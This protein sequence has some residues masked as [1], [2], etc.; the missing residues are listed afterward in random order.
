MIIT[1]IIL[2]AT[3]LKYTS[4]SVEAIRPNEYYDTSDDLWT[5]MTITYVLF[6]VALLKGD[7]EEFRRFHDQI[8]KRNNSI[9]RSMLIK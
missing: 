6:V 5:C 9:Q 8:G 3:S 2:S 1:N 7:T 4:Q